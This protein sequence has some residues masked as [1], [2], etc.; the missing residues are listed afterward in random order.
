[1]CVPENSPGVRLRHALGFE[2]RHA[3]GGDASLAGAYRFYIDDWGL[4]SHTIRAEASYLTD[5]DTILS[6]RYRFYLQS[7]A[8]HYRATYLAVQPYVTSDKELSPLSSHRL[9]LE[10]DRVWRL[11]DGSSFT[12]TIS[13]A[14]L[15]YA[16]SDFIPLESMTGF[17]LSAGIMYA[18]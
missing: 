11:D 6:A 16:Y 18:P 5:A 13:V 9:A 15:Y 2:L 12:T 14:P 4:T 1:L 3:L 7:A 8:D 10:L 17:E